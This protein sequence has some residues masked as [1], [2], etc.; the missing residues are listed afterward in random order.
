M[1][2]LWCRIKPL[3]IILPLVL[4]VWSGCANYQP[5]TRNDDVPMFK[6]DWKSKEDVERFVASFADTL[7][8]TTADAAKIQKKRKEQ[9]LP[10]IDAHLKLYFITKKARGYTADG[11]LA[12]GYVLMEN[13]EWDGLYRPEV[14]NLFRTNLLKECSKYGKPVYVREIS[15]LDSD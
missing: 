13:I 5:V 7:K 3:T 8:T 11:K 12:E 9:K 14:I 1:N 4:L 10:S 15:L 6:L 2:T